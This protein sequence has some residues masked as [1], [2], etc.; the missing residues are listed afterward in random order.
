MGFR[1]FI[2]RWWFY[3]FFVLVFLVSDCFKGGLKIWYLWRF[4]VVEIVKILI[5]GIVS[6]RC[7]VVIFEF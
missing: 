5:E 6:Y 1:V 2:E 7:E 4:K 3:F